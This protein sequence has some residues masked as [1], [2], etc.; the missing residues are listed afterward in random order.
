[1]CDISHMLTLNQ[2]ISEEGLTHEACAQRI[3]ISRS[4]L[5]E[6]LSGSKMPGRKAIERIEAAT[7]GRVPASVW[8]ASGAVQNH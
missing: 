4:Y 3:G 8:F 6:I 5:T 1:M 2:Y 7:G